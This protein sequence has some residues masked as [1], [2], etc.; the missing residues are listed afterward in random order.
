MKF[1]LRSGIIVIVIV[2]ALVA[3]E[4]D[5]FSTIV[6]VGECGIVVFYGCLSVSCRGRS[7]VGLEDVEEWVGIPFL[8]HPR[9]A[10][11]DPN[12]LPFE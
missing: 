9:I 12:T 5:V 10:A 3:E 11:R 6:G 8:F 2:K 1:V 4:G 7:C